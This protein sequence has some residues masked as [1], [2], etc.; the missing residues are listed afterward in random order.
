MFTGLTAT[1]TIMRFVV[2]SIVQELTPN[3]G[4]SLKDQVSRIE[5]R[6]DDLLTELATKK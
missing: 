1:Y 6:L 2:K 4:S 5:R 3:S